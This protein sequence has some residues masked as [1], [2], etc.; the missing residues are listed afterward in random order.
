MMDIQG[1]I[2][3]DGNDLSDLIESYLEKF[4]RFRYDYKYKTLL[5][6]SIIKKLGN[7]STNIK[8]QKENPLTLVVCGEF[9]RGKSS[10][11]NAILG[12]DVVTTNITTETITVNKIS[13]GAHKNEIIL[14]GGKRLVLSDDELKCDNLK[15]ILADLPKDSIQLEL[16]RPL[17]ILKDVTIIDTPGLG[18]AMKDFEED[19]RMALAQADAVI[20]VYSV[21]YPLSL[22]EQLFIKTV[23]KPQKYTDLF[24]LGNYADM[25]E[26]IESCERVQNTIDQRL[27]N[28][29]PDEKTIM[30]SALD[31]RCRQKGAKRPN[32]ELE[33]FLT[34]NF[35]KFREEL[36]RL[37]TE[38]REC[39]L[40][41][42]MQRLLNGMIA[43]IKA[44]IVAITEGLSME[45]GEIAQKLKELDA[46]K[47]EQIEEQK[48]LSEHIENMIDVFKAD[49]VGWIEEVINKMEAEA[50]T[51]NKY[52]ADDVKKFYS[53]YCL[54]TLQNAL[55]LC[56]DEC[57]EALY[58]ELDDISS[59]VSKNMAFDTS[60]ASTRFSF[61][62]R[63]KTWTA[64]DN[65]AFVSTTVLNGSYL[66][67]ATDLLGG[68]MRE[69]T[70]KK[71]V[72]DLVSEIKAQY[73]ELRISINKA[74]SEAYDNIGAK[75]KQQLSE[76][77]ESELAACEE[78]VTRS[79]AVAKQD[80][81]KKEEIKNALCELENVITEIETDISSI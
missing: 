79:A 81:A 74:I 47:D 16:K 50:D 29:L 73:L 40:P 1:R 24:L 2:I 13:Y 21:A 30:I 48:K 15:N 3:Y 26:D 14:Q 63:N 55:T 51:L 71:S 62:L 44:D 7:W 67:L 36:R 11:I 77:F 27:A 49:T 32:A 65:V 25:L 68:L 42:R 20:Y 75:A 28:V 34:Q 39:V 38:K 17:E 59:D 69:H 9:K 5:G 37:L 72:P 56:M 57:I 8:K 31:E 60:S 12:E 46:Y 52:P 54:E 66:S 61:A 80:D 45:Q 78:R 53:L 41:D 43:D 58:D 10:L 70:I 23:I 4:E 19:V 22:N 76:H 6:E 64:G 18:D 35:D 33:D